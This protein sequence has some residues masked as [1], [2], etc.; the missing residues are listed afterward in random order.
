MPKPKPRQRLSRSEA[1]VVKD[2][3]NYSRDHREHLMS[4]HKPVDDDAKSIRAGIAFF[5]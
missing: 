2:A 4:C 5:I 3:L 1:A